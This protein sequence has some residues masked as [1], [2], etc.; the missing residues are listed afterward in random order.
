MIIEHGLLAS[1]VE[2][3]KKMGEH[4]KCGTGAVKARSKILTGLDSTSPIVGAL[5]DLCGAPVDG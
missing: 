1:K 4:V 5:H 3:D 2:S